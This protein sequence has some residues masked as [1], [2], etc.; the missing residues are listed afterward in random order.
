MQN[1]ND[2]TRAL[3]KVKAGEMEYWV[4]TIIE[5]W[6]SDRPSDSIFMDDAF[7]FDR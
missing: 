4:G 2:E 1:H 7:L 3:T 5:V 6:H